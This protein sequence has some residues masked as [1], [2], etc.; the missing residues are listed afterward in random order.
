[1]QE[2]LWNRYGNAEKDPRCANCMMH[3]GFESATIFGAISSPKDA[4]SLV[5]SGAITKSGITAA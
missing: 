2:G 3:C 5:T 1:M 4:V